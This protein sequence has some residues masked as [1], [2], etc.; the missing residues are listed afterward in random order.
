MATTER[1]M[2]IG[3]NTRFSKT[4]QPANPGRKPS[5][6]KKFITEAGEVE[7][8]NEDIGR[9]INLIIDMNEAELK[10]FYDDKTKPV[11]L[12]GFAG[13]VAAEVKKHGL[14]NIMVLL[15]RSFGK[16]AESIKHSGSIEFKSL[17]REEKEEQIKALEK[18][19]K[20]E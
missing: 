3:K 16:A 17:T 6:I 7:L 18:L 4:N 14:Q 19:T 11:V 12:R 9:A 10:A 20:S 15:E 13:A 1:L 2:E 8:S 5:K